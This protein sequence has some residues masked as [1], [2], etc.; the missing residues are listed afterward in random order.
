MI[1]PVGYLLF[2]T[3][4]SIAD[5]SVPNN[6]IAGNVGEADNLG[7]SS[8]AITITMYTVTDE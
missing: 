7:S 1:M 5:T 6:E 3:S 8:A 4:I 2:D